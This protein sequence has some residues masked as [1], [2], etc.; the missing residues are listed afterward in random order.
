MKKV[1]AGVFA[2]SLIGT[3][4]VAAPDKDKK[5][6]KN[7]NCPAC[8]MEMKSKAT[9]DCNTKVTYKGKTYY[10]CPKCPMAAKS[11]KHKKA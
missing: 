1:L 2:L 6:H 11:D 3:A 9:K 10:C 5:A 4:A 8:K 7:P